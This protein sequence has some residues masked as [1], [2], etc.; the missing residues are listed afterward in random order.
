[1]VVGPAAE[2]PSEYPFF[3]PDRLLIDAGETPLHQT[4]CRKF[5]IFIAV[6]AEPVAAIVAVFVG[7][8]HGNAIVGEGPK[9]LDESV[10]Q[11]FRPFPFEK[12]LRLCA[13]PRKFSTIAPLRLLGIGQG[14]P[15]RVT[16]VPPIFGEAYLFPGGFFGERRKWRT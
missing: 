16:A 7:I 1:M 6:S 15:G 2:R 8:S 3:L 4:I 5:P 10:V 13:S 14:Y 12:C 9:L 11:L